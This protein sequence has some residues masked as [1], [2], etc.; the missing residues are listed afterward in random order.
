MRTTPKAATTE[1]IQVVEARQQRL[2]DTGGF[3]LSGERGTADRECLAAR[4][5]RCARRQVNS[6]PLPEWTSA[7]LIHP[8]ARRHDQEPRVKS[9]PLRCVSARPPASTSAGHRH[10]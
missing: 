3:L 10:V 9:P 7:G 5:W 2:E 1:A 6:E 4:V 8:A